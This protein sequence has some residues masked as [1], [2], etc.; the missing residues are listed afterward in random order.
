MNLLNDLKKIIRKQLT[1]YGVKW[2][3]NDDVERLL[4]RVLN[5]ESKTIRAVPRTVHFST[6]FQAER[7]K[8]PAKN[9]QALTEIIDKFRRGDEVN[10]HLSKKSLET[11]PTDQLLAHWGVH[12][13]HIS[14]WKKNA[15]DY[16]YA[17][18]GPLVFA[19]VGSNDVYFLGIYPH[20]G[21]PETWTRQKLLDT[22]EKNWP[23]LLDSAEL[24]GAIELAYDPTDQDL[25]S[26]RKA[27]INTPT[28]VGGRIVGPP[29]GG[30][31]TNGTPMRHK[32]RAIKTIKGIEKLQ[33][34]VD[35]NRDAIAK[36]L[37]LSPTA[38][39][40]QLGQGQ[41]GWQVRE[42]KTGKVVAGSL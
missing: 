16:F 15:G 9:K 20:G 39:D 36:S 26:L 11:A 33:K 19:L 10:A 18:T 40:F 12:H 1:T 2:S 24:K 27:N 4:L 37:G 34:D 21:H 13:V 23:Q 8:L 41:T 38:I 42:R 31:M 14:N 32:L 3:Q 30:V 28:K 7:T 35:A 6:G 25:I 29:G 17:R 22:V 5:L